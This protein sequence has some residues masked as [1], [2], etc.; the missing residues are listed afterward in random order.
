MLKNSAIFKSIHKDDL[1]KMADYRIEQLHLFQEQGLINTRGDFFPSVHY[2]PITMYPSIDEASFFDG[3]TLPADGLFDIYVHFPFCI[4]QCAFCHYPVKCGPRIADKDQYIKTLGREIEL[5]RK[6][7]GVATLKARSILIGGG[8]PTYLTPEQ[9]DRFLKMFTNKIDTS[10]C[11][12]FNYDVD[13]SS[14][15][16]SQGKER[17][18]IM[19]TYGVDRLT[20]GTQS[21]DDR[22]LKLMNRAHNS[23][24]AIESV[25]A[26][27]KTGF[28][29]NIEF[30][31][32]YPFQTMDTWIDTIERAIALET[33]EIQLYR[34]KIDAY[35]DRQGPIKNAHKKN[36]NDFPGVEE[37][38]KM[39]QLGAMML[40]MSGYH[41]NLTRVF[42]KDPEIF[43]HYASN[44][45]CNLYDQIGFGVTGFSSLRNRFSINTM[46]F[47]EYHDLVDQGSIPLNR[48]LVRDTEDQLRWALILPLKNRTVYK[49]DY[50]TQTGVS[51]DVVFRDIIEMLKRYGLLKEDEKTL[52]LTNT[53]R[54]FADEVCEQFHHVD[55]MPFPQ[56]W[57]RSGDLN[58]FNRKG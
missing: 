4:S 40:N 57:Y 13:P 44:Q 45:C 58:P 2:P 17:L 31:F 18:K 7:L 27:Q 5:Y 11:T 46:D 15:I 37:A 12:Q 20:I 33:D 9:L 24:E 39:K 22:I 43:S 56:S 42:S 50:R 8:T 32:G 51:F 47:K 49:Q 21:L 30:I 54:F 16:G 14:L 10:S 34:L 29:V 25:E 28:V 48:G 53:G 38:L 23:Q 19:K 1:L 41:E 36:K 55:T 26:S 35:G 52:S 6:R 3:Y